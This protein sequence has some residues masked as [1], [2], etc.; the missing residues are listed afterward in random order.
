PARVFLDRGRV[1]L[2]SGIPFGTGGA[3]HVRLNLATSPEVI[4]EAVRRMRAALE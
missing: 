3:G 2:S 1:A 4:A